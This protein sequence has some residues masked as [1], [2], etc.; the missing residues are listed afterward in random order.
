MGNKKYL[1]PADCRKICH[2]HDLS[3]PPST[4][5]TS[6]VLRP[7]KEHFKLVTAFADRTPV[8]W[9]GQVCRLTLECSIWKFGRANHKP[10]CQRAR[11]SVNPQVS[12]EASPGQPPAHLLLVGGRRSARLSLSKKSV[13]VWEQKEDRGLVPAATAMWLR[14]LL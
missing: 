13:W 11:H 14:F 1:L 4:L 12:R 5:D 7:S 9:S 2:Q 6:T 8:S 3:P 10:W